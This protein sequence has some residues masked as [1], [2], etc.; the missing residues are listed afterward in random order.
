MNAETITFQINII[1][2]G[3]DASTFF[4]KQKLLDLK[5][6]AHLEY[7]PAPQR[8]LKKK[9]HAASLHKGTSKLPP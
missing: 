3:R 8:T 7:N 1:L 4:L 5:F 2:G 6:R 9:S